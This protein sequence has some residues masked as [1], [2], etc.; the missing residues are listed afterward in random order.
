MKLYVARHGETTWNVEK[1]ILGHTP[2]DLTPKGIQQAAV[3]AEQLI[4]LNI[5][6]CYASDLKRVVETVEIVRNRIGSFQVNYTP[7][8]RERNFGNLEGRF[9]SEVDW[10]GFWALPPTE[11]CYGAESVY[12]FTARIARYVVDLAET[13][14]KTVL[15]LTHIGV[16]NRLH[17]LSSP[18][19]SEFIA[20]SNAEALPFDMEKLVENSHAFL[21]GSLVLK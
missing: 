20:Y 17:F 21:D 7:T 2:G 1:R 19:S 4:S 6:T 10:D 3:L 11:S 15:L 16:M 12:D 14:E 13:S 8:L 9:V 5:H 18:S